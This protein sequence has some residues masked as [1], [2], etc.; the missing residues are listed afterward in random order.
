M[1][2][3]QYNRRKIAAAERLE[4]LEVLSVKKKAIYKV[5]IWKK[6]FCDKRQLLMGSFKEELLEKL[7]KN[8]E[9]LWN[10]FVFFLNRCFCEEACC[11]PKT[12]CCFL[13]PFAAFSLH[14]P[15]ET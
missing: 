5:H 15:V 12:W 6:K 9:S 11:L 2:E 10:P 8:R 1:E 14:L 7:L 3:M 4:W 13:I